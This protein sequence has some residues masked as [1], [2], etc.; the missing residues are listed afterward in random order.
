V[1]SKISYVK[2][3][4][5]HLDDKKLYR[6]LGED[7]PVVRDKLK[8]EYMTKLKQLL[9]HHIDSINWTAK[10]DITAASEAT[11]KTAQLFKA[12]IKIH[13]MDVYFKSIIS[14][15]ITLAV[16]FYTSILS[17]Y[18]SDYLVLVLTFVKSYVR[19]STDALQKFFHVDLHEEK[20]YHS[21]TGD[22]PS[23]FT[24]IPMDIDS[25]TKCADYTLR[26]AREAGIAHT[27]P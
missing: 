9:D 24:N 21:G 15:P 20:K 2:A 22:I 1:L 13:K 8:R 16:D 4:L 25:I 7:E 23:M 27:F 10:G 19:D 14:R 5:K 18:I 11:K 17:R 12:I 6:S 3:L 26:L